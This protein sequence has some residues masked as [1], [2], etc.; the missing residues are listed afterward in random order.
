MGTRDLYMILEWVDVPTGTVIATRG[1]NLSK[2]WLRT[3]GQ[4][5][6]TKR[7]MTDEPHDARSVGLTADSPGT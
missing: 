1:L 7:S 2:G 6:Q 4:D 5:L 3:W